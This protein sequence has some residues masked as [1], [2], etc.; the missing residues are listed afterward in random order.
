MDLRKLYILTNGG[1]GWI[2]DLKIVLSEIM[3]EWD[4]VLS[5]HD[6]ALTREQGYIGQAIDM[7]IA[8]QADVFIGN[9][10]SNFDSR[11]Y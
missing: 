5:G 2:D 9:G 4:V 3:S 7:S 1:R 6:L 8:E 10:V 11:L